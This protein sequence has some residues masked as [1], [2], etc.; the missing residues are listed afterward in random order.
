MHLGYKVNHALP[1]RLSEKLLHLLNIPNG[2]SV[3]LSSGSEAVN[4][5]ITIA[6]ENTGRENILTIGNSY[7]SAYGHGRRGGDNPNLVRIDKEDFGA[8]KNLD[9][10][11][12]A[13]FVFE[14]G[15]FGGIIHLH[16]NEFVDEIL[17]NCIQNDCLVIANDVTTGFGRTGKWFGFQHYNMVPD[18]VVTGKAMGNG[19]PVSAVSVQEKVWQEFE[20]KQIR[21]AQSHQNDPLGCAVGLEVIRLLSEGNLIRRSQESGNYFLNRLSGLADIKHITDVRGRGLMLAIEFQ[22]GF[23]TTKLF[24]QLFE[25]GILVGIREQVLRFMPPLTIKNEEIDNLVRKL[26]F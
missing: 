3:F 14:P 16:S 22:E 18:M 26:D 23:D 5:A 9:F 7:L 21:Y 8:L 13:T 1:A 10:G 11:S 2:K 20:K 12:I 17:R 25:A 24:R 15:N 4:L 6:K 19:Y